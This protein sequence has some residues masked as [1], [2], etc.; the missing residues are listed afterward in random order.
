MHLE[1]RTTTETLAA[2][3]T[4]EGLAAL[5]QVELLGPN[6]SQIA[7]SIFRPFGNTQ[8]K[9]PRPVTFTF[10]GIYDGDNLID[11]VILCCESESHV[12]IC[13]HGSRLIV[14]DLLE[15]LA[16]KGASRT[17][18][19]TFTQTLFDNTQNEIE[20]EAHRKRLNSLTLDG[21]KAID[22]QTCHGL[23]KTLQTWLS[24]DIPLEQIQKQS[25]NILAASEPAARLINGAELIIAGPPNAGK[26]TL[27]NHLTARESALVSE[28]PGTTRDYIHAHIR[29]KKLYIRLYD[30]AGLD[31]TLTD[32]NDIDSRA[33]NRSI[34]LIQSAHLVLWLIDAAQFSSQYQSD[35]LVEQIQSHCAKSIPAEKILPVLTKIDQANP[36]P[37]ID[38]LQ[39]SAQTGKGIKTLIYEIENRLGVKNFQVEQPLCFTTRQ[40]ALIEQIRDSK[41]PDQA[42]TRIQQL[43]SARECV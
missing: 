26:S 13:T 7:G 23:V 11:E 32:Q 28:T 12:R 34:Q 36:N 6:A 25:K 39:V 9:S 38:I 40:K 8:N 42:K 15:L 29:S 14:E 30:T 17:D 41:T 31:K 4:F 24:E 33:Q 21:V 2:M 43:L 35:N 18:F 16:G 1:T 10:G 19:D 5:A 3:T 22:Y 37:D 27:F 20:K